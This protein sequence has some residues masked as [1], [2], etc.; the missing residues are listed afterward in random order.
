L[1]NK[2]NVEKILKKAG[3]EPK[4]DYKLSV[5]PISENF[6]R[7]IVKEIITRKNITK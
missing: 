6:L 5:E 4:K 1:D 3:L 7:G 2:A